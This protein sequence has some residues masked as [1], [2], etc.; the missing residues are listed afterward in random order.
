MATTLRRILLDRARRRGAGK[1]AT[2][3]TARRI[4]GFNIHLYRGSDAR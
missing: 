4:N 1:R 3:E 2:E